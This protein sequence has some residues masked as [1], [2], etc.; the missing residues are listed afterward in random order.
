[1]IDVSLILVD[2]RCMNLYNRNHSQ[3]SK[4][5]AFSPVHLQY[6]LHIKLAVLQST[7]CYGIYTSA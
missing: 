7:I 5:I 2:D 3:K 4:K 1:M 6:L